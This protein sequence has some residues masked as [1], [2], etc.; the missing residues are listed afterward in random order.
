MPKSVGRCYSLCA[1]VALAA[2]LPA[3]SSP[4]GPSSISGS[5]DSCSGAQG[6]TVP[7]F[8][9]VLTDSDGTLT[10]GA[11]TASNLYTLTGTYRRP[12]VS[13]T[14]VPTGGALA[15]TIRFDGTASSGKLV[16]RAGGPDPETFTFVRG[17]VV[18]PGVT[19]N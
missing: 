12:H 15:D 8:D 19:A 13:F 10:G 5:W 4:T 7:C 2:V 1:V 6:A 9:L 3:C 11:E 16:L 17:E 14:L 18:F